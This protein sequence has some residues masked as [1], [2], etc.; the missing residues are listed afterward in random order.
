MLLVRVLPLI[1]IRICDRNEQMLRPLP[2]LWVSDKTLNFLS[3]SALCPLKFCFSNPKTE[4]SQWINQCVRKKT[5]VLLNNAI[6]L[7]LS[8]FKRHYILVVFR[9]TAAKMHFPHRRPL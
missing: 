2:S 6:S 8:F 9:G 7:S 3:V 1:I 5:E 4:Q